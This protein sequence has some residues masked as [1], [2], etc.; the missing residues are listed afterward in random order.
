MDRMIH[1]TIKK[2]AGDIENMKFNTAI[3]QMMIAL[4]LITEKKQISSKNYRLYLILLAPF[5][6]HLAEELWAKLE[7][8]KSIF[9]EAWPTYD[10]TLAK[11]EMIELV[12]SINGKV[13]DR[14]RVSADITEADAKKLAEE[15]ESIKKWTK[16]KEIVKVV[17]VKGRLLNIVLK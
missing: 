13:R 14:I 8:K 7:N 4:N 1:K 6:P 15:S 17:F 16:G 11:D 12:L 2:V 5:A 9:A 3:S 10:E